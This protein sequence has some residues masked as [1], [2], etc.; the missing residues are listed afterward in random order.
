M[1]LK[2][3]DTNN[4]LT[5][6][7]DELRVIQSKKEVLENRFDNCGDLEYIEA[8]I[9]EQKALESHYNYVLNRVRRMEQAAAAM[10]KKK[11]SFFDARPKPEMHQNGEQPAF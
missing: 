1:T 10:P 11:K 6:L 9:Y 8:I 3:F 7:K 4:G 5:Q 2:V